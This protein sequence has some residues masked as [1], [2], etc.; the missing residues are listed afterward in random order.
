MAWA[1]LMMMKWTLLAACNE[2]SGS[3][4]LVSWVVDT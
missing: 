2:P 4:K 1:G 3:I